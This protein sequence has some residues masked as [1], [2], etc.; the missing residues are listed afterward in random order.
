MLKYMR[1]FKSASLIRSDV[2]SHVLRVAS[3]ST[4]I[5]ELQ[6]Y[7]TDNLKSYFAEDALLFPAETI[8]EKT[9]L[10]DFDF[11]LQQR[12][13]LKVVDTLEKFQSGLLNVDSDA[14][15]SFILFKKELYA[16]Y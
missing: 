8:I 12:N 15:R 14:A 1:R 10:K 13:F 3:K 9:S 4:H 2:P 5:Y 7:Q 6:E 16:M 11:F